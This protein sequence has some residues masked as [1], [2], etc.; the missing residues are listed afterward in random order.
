MAKRAS[1]IGF[2]PLANFTNAKKQKTSNNALISFSTFT[3][4]NEA[5]QRSIASLTNNPSMSSFHSDITPDNKIEDP[6][7][8]P[9]IVTFPVKFS[10]TVDTSFAKGVVVVAEYEQTKT[11]ETHGPFRS[12]VVR[13]AA[14]SL[15]D[16][17]ARVAVVL[18][19]SCSK[20]D[21]ARNYTCLF[22]GAIADTTELN[23]GT[24][25]HTVGQ[26]MYAELKSAF[27]NGQTNDH[28][29]FKDTYSA[30]TILTFQVIYEQI[31]LSN[32]L[33][34]ILPTRRTTA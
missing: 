33:V 4:G 6:S 31:G 8:S 7:V 29:E 23:M 17:D 10:P 26:I 5:E 12:V 21:A 22:S 18:A 27:S 3:R 1:G 11:P 25:K 2:T 15:G 30:A 9:I 24:T 14:T 13:T 34:T 32:A 20:P 28:I 19:E 16:N